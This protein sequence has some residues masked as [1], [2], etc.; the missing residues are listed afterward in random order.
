MNQQYIK[1]VAQINYNSDKCIG[2]KMCTVVCP[3]AVFRMQDKK[4]ILVKKDR[5]M[6]CGACMKNCIGEAIYVKTGVGCATAVINSML[7]KHDGE[8]SCGCDV[9]C[10]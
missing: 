3:H 1:G 5:C 2:C 4:A 6:E 10:C 7:G 9:N 8:I